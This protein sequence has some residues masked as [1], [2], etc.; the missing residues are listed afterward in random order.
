MKK[1]LTAILLTTITVISFAQGKLKP[2]AGVFLDKNTKLPI[3]WLV[4]AQPA[5]KA[6]AKTIVGKDGRSIAVSFAPTISHLDFFGNAIG[7]EAG[8]EFTLT[9]KIK[10]T[11]KVRLAYLAY[12]AN[13]EFL[14]SDNGKEFVLTGE[15]QEISDKFKVKNGK[16]YPVAKIRPS[17][18][19]G[20]GTVCEISS[21]VLTD[22]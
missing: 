11:G 14:F 17:V 18:R 20:K 13:N 7:F 4:Q 5:D 22:E 8:D 19:I 12:K 15:E 9:V 21:V 2:V 10:G 16:D 6:T 3:Y 1:I